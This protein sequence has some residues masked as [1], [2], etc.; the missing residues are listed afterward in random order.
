MCMS[1]EF[2]VEPVKFIRDLVHGYVYITKFELE[3]IDTPEFQRLKDIRQLTCQHVYTAARH[4]RFEHSLGVLELARQAVKIINRNRFIMENV[5]IEIFNQ[6]IQF[7]ASLA[8]LLHDIGHCPFSHLGETEF[9]KAVVWEMLYEDIQ[10]QNYFNNGE[11]QKK[12]DEM[13]QDAQKRKGAVHEQLSCV[14]IL[15]NLYKK[16]DKVKENS[17][18]KHG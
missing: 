9:N 10:E 6:Q 3:I 5:D 11:F 16:L 1:I 13:N 7:N 14:L 12:I 2:Y 8:A 4:S 18:R 17:N 15:E